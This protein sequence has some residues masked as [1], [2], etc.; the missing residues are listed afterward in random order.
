MGQ[1]FFITGVILATII[2]D[3]AVRLRYRILSGAWFFVMI[4]ALMIP[5]H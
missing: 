3:S 5:H 1:V 2:L 4:L